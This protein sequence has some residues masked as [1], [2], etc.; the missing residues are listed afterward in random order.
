MQFP[1]LAHFFK[2]GKNCFLTMQIS[3]DYSFPYVKQSKFFVKQLLQNIPE[4]Y[5]EYASD[6]LSFS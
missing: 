6:S 1:T 5:Q 2:Y 3:C 4:I